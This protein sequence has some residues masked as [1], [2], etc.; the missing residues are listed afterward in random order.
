MNR[1]AIIHRFAVMLCCVLLTACA[2]KSPHPTEPE[3]FTARQWRLEY[4]GERPVIDFSNTTIFFGRDGRVSGNG[5][6]NAYS[7]KWELRDGKLHIGPLAATMALCP[8]EAVNE[9]ESRFFRGL[10]KAESASVH[11]ETGALHIFME[12]EEQPMIFHEI[13]KDAVVKGALT[14]RERIALGPEAVAIVRLLDVSRQDAAAPVLAE[15]RIENPGQVP[16]R[17]HLEYDPKLIKPGMRY[18]IRA[19]I[20]Y[21]GR[22]MFTTTEHHPLPKD[23]GPVNILLKMPQ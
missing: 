22:L 5:G 6:C 7:G 15:Q 3:D 9:Q 1:F 11:P 2:V 23:G 16:I 10:A 18:A 4:I 13:K 8:A 12:G 17:F 20:R 21:M 14:Y 19:E